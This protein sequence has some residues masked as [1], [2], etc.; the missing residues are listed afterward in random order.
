MTPQMVRVEWIDSGMARTNGWEKAEDIIEGLRRTPEF[1]RVVSVGLLLF[2][3]EEQVILAQS[4]DAHNENFVNAH[5]IYRP[6]VI[7]I[8]PLLAVELPAPRDDDG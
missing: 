6:N 3:D 5:G 7:S 8:E 4:Y 2:Q 1:M